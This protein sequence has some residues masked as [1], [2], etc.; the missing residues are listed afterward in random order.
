VT[1]VADDFV[2]FQRPCGVGNREWDPA[3][4]QL[5]GE[6]HLTAIIGHPPELRGWRPGDPCVAPQVHRT[7]RVA[8]YVTVDAGT[9]RAT[10]IGARSWLM[11]HVHVGH[12]AVIGEDC[13]VAPGVVVCGHVTLGDRVKVG[14]NATILPHRVIG[15]DVTIGAGAV[16]TSDVPAGA[17]VVGNPARI[18]EPNPVPHTARPVDQRT[19]SP[20]WLH[21]RAALPASCCKPVTGLSE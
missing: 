2:E 15:D 8:A 12:D 7:A 17:T 10:L 4:G 6:I 9:V 13:E 1:T 3:E 16:V 20:L 14:V 11:K 18:I 21:R 19:A 5:V